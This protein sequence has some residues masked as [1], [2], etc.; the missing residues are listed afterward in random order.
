MN[1][2]AENKVSLQ[3]WVLM[4]INQ[5]LTLP[6]PSHKMNQMMKTLIPM[7]TEFAPL[8]SALMLTKK[9][10]DFKINNG[11]CR[12]GGIGR[13]AGLRSQ[14]AQAHAGSNPA[15]GTIYYVA[16]EYS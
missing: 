14:W 16:C 12:G 9:L 4:K 11:S 10:L 3:S 13:R 5:T 1:A 6:T 8:L 15:R 7:R 2:T